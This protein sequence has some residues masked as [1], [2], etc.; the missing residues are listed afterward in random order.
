[1]RI[2]IAMF[3]LGAGALAASSAVADEHGCKPVDATIVTS[4]VACPAD[5]QSPVGLCTQGTIDSGPLKGT[6]LFRAMTLVPGSAD[7]MLYTGELRITTKHGTVT[8]K[9]AGVLDAASGRYFEAQT[10]VGGTRQF[11]HVSGLLTSQ[12]F[13]VGTGF[14]GTLTGAICHGNGH[15]DSDDRK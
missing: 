5:F 8:L 14:V 6:T 15:R 1:M 12:G 2:P 10:V 7:T 3:V 9:D 11:E 4:F 13:D